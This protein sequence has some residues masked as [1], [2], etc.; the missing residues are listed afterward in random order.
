M[1]TPG[2]PASRAS[3]QIGERC[4]GDL[5]ARVVRRRLQGP[6]GI[7]HGA[8]GGGTERRE[9]MKGNLDPLQHSE[10]LGDPREC[11]R[12]L[13]GE[14]AGGRVVVIRRREHAIQREH[15]AAHARAG[16][17]GRGRAASARALGSGRATS[18]RVV[19]SG[20]VS[21]ATLSA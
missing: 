19:R 13:A 14:R 10:R 15:L 2:P 12:L 6:P 3:N 11:L 18:T 17:L 21:V 1:T 20:S 7:E 4:L 16:E 5:R 9:G 8:E